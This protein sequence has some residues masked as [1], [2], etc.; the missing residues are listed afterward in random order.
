[1]IFTFFPYTLPM[2]RSSKDILILLKEGRTEYKYQ[3]CRNLH[4]PPFPPP[5]TPFMLLFEPAYPI[6]PY[7]TGFPRRAS[8]QQELYVKI[9]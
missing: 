7:T 2:C 1:M 5:E 8:L 3:L 4:S 6:E 9:I